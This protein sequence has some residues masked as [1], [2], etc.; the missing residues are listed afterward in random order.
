MADI[1]I[2]FEEIIRPYEGLYSNHPEDNGGETIWGI[3]RKKHA[4]AFVWSLVD[5]A[6]MKSGFPENMRFDYDILNTVHNFYRAHF[7]NK[8]LLDYVKDQKVAN[9]VFDIAVNC[10]TATGGMYLQRALNVLNRNGKDY[11]DLIVDGIVGPKTLNVI[12]N[13]PRTD[14]VLKTLNILQGYRYI[15]LSELEK[16][17]EVFTNGWLERIKL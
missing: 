6:K 17:Y 9:E 12:N 15:S 14:R 10:G 8:L 3:A 1:Q 4:S 7:W 13:H 2:A 11:A 16:N 5:A